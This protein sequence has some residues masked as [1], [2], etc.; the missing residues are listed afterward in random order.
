MNTKQRWTLIKLSAAHIFG[1]WGCQ[2]GAQALH[3]NHSA[4]YRA[5]HVAAYTATITAALATH[6]VPALRIVAFALV[7]FPLHYLVDSVRLPKWLDQ[8]IHLAQLALC[9]RILLAERSSE[10][11]KAP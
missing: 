6:Q 3:K 11:G 10:A 7:T 4:Y 5:Q 9:Y 8:T 2:T 1:D